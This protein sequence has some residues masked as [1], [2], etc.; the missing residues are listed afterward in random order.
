MEN[1]YLETELAH[2]PLSLVFFT[3]YCLIAVCIRGI[4][5]IE[6]GEAGGRECKRSGLE[7]QRGA[8]SVLA[9][10]HN[11]LKA[12]KKE[13]NELWKQRQNVLS[14]RVRRIRARGRPQELHRYRWEEVPLLLI[15]R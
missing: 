13:F 3:H 9:T 2:A 1:F 6:C 11:I 8:Y 12:L 4:K 10:R 7:R 5:I 15:H 14:C